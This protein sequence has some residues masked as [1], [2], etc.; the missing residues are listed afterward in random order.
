ML[1][2]SSANFLHKT[3]STLLRIPNNPK[4]YKICDL[5]NYTYSTIHLVTIRKF[6]VNIANRIKYVKH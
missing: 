3:K 2:S 4:I 5:T 1:N 6:Y